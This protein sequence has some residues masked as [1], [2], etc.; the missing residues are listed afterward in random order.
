MKREECYEMF[1]D[2][3]AF[4]VIVDRFGS[5]EAENLT[6]EKVDEIRVQAWAFMGDAIRAFGPRHRLFEDAVELVYISLINEQ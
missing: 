5:E 1:L 4:D 6:A 2:R 3:K